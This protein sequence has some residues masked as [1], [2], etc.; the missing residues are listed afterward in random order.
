MYL[1]FGFIKR[2][3]TPDES[4]NQ[5]GTE[6]DETGQEKV[7]YHK[8]GAKQED[9]VLVLEFKDQPKLSL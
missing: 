6:T 3:E 4:K 8:I 7:Y 5:T 2:Y 1:F 9:D